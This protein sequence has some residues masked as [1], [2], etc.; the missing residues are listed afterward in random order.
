R[1]SRCSTRRIVA[2]IET[3]RTLQQRYGLGFRFGDDEGQTAFMAG[4]AVAPLRASS[5]ESGGYL[6]AGGIPHISAHVHDAVNSKQRG[7]EGCARAIATRKQPDHPRLVC[8]G[9]NAGK[10]AGPKQ[11]GGTG[12]SEGKG[13]G[14]SGPNWTKISFCRFLAKP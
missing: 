5:G 14:L 1:P 12:A 8:A 4:D 6:E 9:G 7:R 13:S 11:V 2:E 10:T 3:R